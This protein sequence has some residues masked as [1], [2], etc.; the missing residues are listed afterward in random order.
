MLW[1]KI[2]LIFMQTAIPLVQCH[3]IALAPLSK[4]DDM[5]MDLFLDSLFHCVDSLFYPYT[6]SILSDY[7]LWN[8]VVYVVVKVPFCLVPSFK[9]AT[10]TVLPLIMMCFNLQMLLVILRKFLFLVFWVL[11]TWIRTEFCKMFFHIY[12]KDHM[13]CLFYSV[14]MVNYIICL[15]FHENQ[16]CCIE[17]KKTHLV[18]LYHGFLKLLKRNLFEKLKWTNRKVQIKKTCGKQLKQCWE[19]IL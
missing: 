13:F 3:W 16:L 12:W 8:T 2:L 4:V 5:H 14:R 17:F 15:F 11:I 18:M 6:N 10:N 1:N 7:Y 19:K 9:G